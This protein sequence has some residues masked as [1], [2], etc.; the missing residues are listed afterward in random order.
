MPDIRLRRPASEA[1]DREGVAHAVVRKCERMQ[2]RGDWRDGRTL[3]KRG[4]SLWRSGTFA[5]RPLAKFDVRRL[6][7]PDRESRRRVVAGQH[8]GAMQD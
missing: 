4:A 6:L 5:R 7:A 1:H 8:P 3:P 2:R